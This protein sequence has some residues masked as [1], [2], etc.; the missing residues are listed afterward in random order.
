VESGEHVWTIAELLERASSGRDVPDEGWLLT[1]DDGLRD[2][3]EY[4]VDI[5]DSQGVKGAFFVPGSPIVESKTMRVQ[6][7]QMIFAAGAPPSEVLAAAQI[8]LSERL[9]AGALQVSLASA[10]AAG[11]KNLLDD[12]VTAQAKYLLQTS[13]SPS[14]QVVL[15]DELLASY[16]CAQDPELHASL[17]LSPA[18]VVELFQGG[19][20]VG[21]HGMLHERYSSMV[22]DE[23]VNDIASSISVLAA[24]GIDCDQ[25]AIAYPYGSVPATSAL[26]N[27]KDI[28]IEIGFT[29]EGRSASPN[30]DWLLLPRWDTI[31]FP[32]AP[33]YGR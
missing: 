31:D 4:V 19:H 3:R 18:G 9:S 13:L 14:D 27:L 30:D 24:L 33:R 28:G 16:S 26:R 17:Y 2:H 11:L 7:I 32:P 25:S 21:P 29:T 23:A 6:K 1:F 8:F 22:S 20:F 10:K 15:L 12:T 5:L